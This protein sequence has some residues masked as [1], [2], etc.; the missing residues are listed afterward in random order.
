MPQFFSATILS[1][2][3]RRFERDD[4]DMACGL[5]SEKVRILYS[6]LWQPVYAGILGAVLLVSIM[7][8][9]VVPSVLISW[10]VAIIAISL[11]RLRLASLYLQSDA[12]SQAHPK[13]I[14]WFACTVLVAGCVWGTAGVLMF[15]PE[16]PEYVAALA[17]TLS[18]VAA[19]SVT[20][21]SAIWWIV[22]LF[23]LPIG[24]PLQWMFLT[25]GVPTHTMMGII[26][27]VFLGLLIVTSR[28][29]GLIIHD[30]ISLRVSMAAREATIYRQANYDALTDLPNRRMFI[31]RLETL[32]ADEK[33]TSGCC[34]LWIWTVLN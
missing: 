1:G 11:F 25:S 24:L 8:E 18:G 15:A 12:T 2:L 31:E 21:I 14:F 4:S 28:R 16:R 3:R 7:W 22:I 13:W 29:L 30:N 34:C 33:Y 27:M 9:V 10:L 5:T 26:M 6:N 17:I 23:L 32:C 19:G 20:M